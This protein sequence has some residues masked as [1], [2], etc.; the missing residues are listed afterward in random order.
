MNWSVQPA[1]VSSQNINS[2]FRSRVLDLLEKLV[3]DE[4]QEKMVNKQSTT[5]PQIHIAGLQAFLGD[6]SGS[7]ITQ[8]V[9]TSVSQDFGSLQKY[10]RSLG[11]EDADI[12]ELNQAISH[13]PLPEA[14]ALLGERV[15]GWIGKMVTKSA[16][17]LCKLSFG[18]AESLLANAIWLY[19]GFGR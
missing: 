13:D 19:Y 16:Q 18:T 9:Q 10:L 5:S 12:S 3:D 1:S 6:V 11:V 15:A 7:V 17:G 4:R 2:E 14:K 8:S